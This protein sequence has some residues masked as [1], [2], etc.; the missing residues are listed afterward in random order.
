MQ[1]TSEYDFIVVGA[2]SAGAVVAT[3]LSED[4]AAE[5]LA[6]EAGGTDIPD[7]VLNPSVWYTLFGSAVAS[8]Q[9]SAACSIK[10]RRN[11]FPARPCGND[12]TKLIELGHLYPTRWPAQNWL[13]SSSVTR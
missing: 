12:G 7:N 10:A 8:D 1:D 13:R 3:R 4:P 11:S 6:L 2:G 9:P 5:V